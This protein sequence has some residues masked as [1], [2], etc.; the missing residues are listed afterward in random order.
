[1]ATKTVSIASNQTHLEINHTISAMLASHGEGALLT[2]VAQAI[3]FQRMKEIA[4]QKPTIRYD[5]PNDTETDHAITYYLAGC[6]GA[7]ALAGQLGRTIFKAGYTEQKIKS[8][9]LCGL[10]EVIYGGWSVNDP[11]L[12]PT[13]P[14]EGWNAWSF[15]RHT[16]KD[17]AHVAPPPGVTIMKGFWHVRLPDGIDAETFDRCVTSAMMSRQLSFWVLSG[18]GR[19]H[20]K[21]H[22]LDPEIFVRLSHDLKHGVLRPTEELY[23]INPRKD[24]AWFA[25]ILGEALA[26]VRKGGSDN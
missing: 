19:A 9:R 21:Q 20:C 10:D 18:E 6:D 15:A 2:S 12:D 11:N 17:T 3:G 4:A 7:K 14:T 16:P 5:D 26:R 8:K 22:G 24:A 1:M 25:T 23:I 13:A